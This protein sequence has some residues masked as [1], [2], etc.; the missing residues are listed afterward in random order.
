MGAVLNFGDAEGDPSQPGTV[1]TQL[2]EVQGG[3]HRV[4]EH[5]PGCL[6]GLHL[7]D[8][9]GLIDDVA[10]ALQLGD[11]ISPGG[12][13][14]QVD[15]AVLVG[16]ELRRAPG[17]VYRL[18][19]E[20]GVGDHLGRV[21]AV[22]LDQPDPGLLVVKKVELLNTVSGLQF[23][24]LRGGIHQMFTVPSVH[25]LDAVGARP[26]VRE[27]DFSQGIRLIV[28]QQL[29]IPPDTE[30]DAGHGLMA[31]AV[32]LDNLQAGQG[33]VL[34][35]V[36]DAVPYHH[37][38]GIGLGIPLPPLRGGQLQNLIC[39]RLQ[40]CEGIGTAGVGGTG[41]GGAALDVLDLYFGSRQA[42]PGGSV[43]LFNSEIAVGFIFK[44]HLGGFPV[45][46]GDLFDRLLIQQVVLR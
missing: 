1:R 45:L 29:P 11:H 30:G 20:P 10:G 35:G 8:A 3:F 46:H 26:A 32:V 16:S 41:I 31:Q 28:P 37:S 5:K 2:D 25:L 40:L 22:H 21:G 7:D 17:T 15:F 6:V 12:Q 13:L 14:G 36:G 9:L 19:A 24:F 33:I 23:N 4:G 18:N 27:Q 38:G 34:Q 42:G 44:V 39:P 43:D